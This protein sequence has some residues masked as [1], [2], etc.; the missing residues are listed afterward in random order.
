MSADAHPRSRPADALVDPSDA[1][2]RFSSGHPIGIEQPE[3]KTMSNYLRPNPYVAWVFMMM[4]A[5]ATLSP[6]TVKAAEESQVRVAGGMA[7]YL[8]VVPAEIVKGHSPAHP[9]RQMHGGGS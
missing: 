8:G 1:R 9:E 5:L 6:S 7:V 2:P 4:H 3:L